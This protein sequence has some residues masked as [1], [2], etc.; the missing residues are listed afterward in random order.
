[1]PCGTMICSLWEGWHRRRARV[2]DNP[3]RVQR[4]TA[5]APD[6]RFAAYRTTRDRGIR[7][8]LVEDHRWLALHCAHRFA[9]K[10]E[11]FDDLVQ[12]AVLGVLKAVERFDPD[13]G[14]RFPSFAMPTV[15]GEL[16][17][18]FRD[19]TWSVHV[20]R[21]IKERYQ[22]VSAVAEEMQA[23]LGRSP[24]VAEIAERV[25]IAV[26]DALE[27]LELRACYRGMPLPDS[28]DDAPTAVADR[29]GVDD[30]DLEAAEA[31]VTVHALLGVL[32]SE[33]DREIIRLRFE[34][35]L[36]QS[37]IAAR[38]GTSQVQVSRLLR[39]GLARM[40]RMFP[41]SA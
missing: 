36:S 40:R 6:P 1:M 19:A 18:H 4:L 30:P 2:S 38:I 17:R 3:D 28:D 26:E 5:E 21:G 16:R 37:Q 11:A 10:G 27:A 39:A 41:A 12:V 13:R 31:R 20:P 35:G 15:L 34:D 14:V 7:N 29:L 9:R 22:T 23:A 33:R 32:P 8:E 25:G 24:T